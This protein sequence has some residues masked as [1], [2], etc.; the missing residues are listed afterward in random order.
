VEF[1]LPGLF[2]S[3]MTLTTMVGVFFSRASSLREGRIHGY[4]MRQETTDAGSSL[5]RR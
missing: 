3:A 2:R 5:F 4:F 1:F